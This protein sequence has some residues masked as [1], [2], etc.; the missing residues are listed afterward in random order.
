MTRKSVSQP[1]VNITSS[2]LTNIVYNASELNYN[3]ALFPSFMVK[4]NS[5]YGESYEWQEGEVIFMP[6]VW[7][8]EKN[9]PKIN[10]EIKNWYIQL[11]L[12]LIIVGLVVSL[13]YKRKKQGY[14]GGV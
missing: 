10:F 8:S 14:E 4:V 1:W 11:L 3:L 5:S 9:R 13:Y 12:P 2:Y 6:L 7:D